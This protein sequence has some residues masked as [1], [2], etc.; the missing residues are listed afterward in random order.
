MP[1]AG[2]DRAVLIAAAAELADRHGYEA[3]TLRALAERFGVAPPSLYS[4]IRSLEA[5]QRELQLE[6]IRRLGDA[7]AR[8]AT[9]RSE[10]RAVR[11]MA[12]AWREFAR[13]HPGLYAATVRAPEPSDTEARAATGR[14]LDIVNAVLSGY[15]LK[16]SASVDAARALRSALHGFVAIE[17]SRGFGLPEELDESYARMV[18]IFIAGLASGGPP[19]ARR[20]GDAASR[21]RRA[22]GS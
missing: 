3:L 2:L 17:A 14:V 5:L 10:A 21:P 19:R 22:R 12:G 18:E 16:A 6:G 11:A 8:A 1:R 15:C 20:T 4:H 9:G 13:D 7:L